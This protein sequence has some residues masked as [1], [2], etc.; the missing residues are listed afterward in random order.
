MEIGSSES[1][2]DDVPDLEEVEGATP[3]AGLAGE[4]LSQGKISR[5]EKKV[6]KALSRL[7]LK[8]VTGITRVT[9]RKSKTVLFTIVRPDV[10]RSPGSD[11]YIVF[12]NPKV[13]FHFVSGEVSA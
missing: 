12:G 3:G 7:G 8:P 9:I 10:F 5:S 1:D 6:R 2:S 13:S 4:T 11:T